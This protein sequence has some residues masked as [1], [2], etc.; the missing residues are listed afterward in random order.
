MQESQTLARNF[1]LVGVI[2]QAKVKAMQN[3]EPQR[4]KHSDLLFNQL[5]S[6]NALPHFDQTC[7]FLILD[8][9]PQPNLKSQFSPNNTSSEL[10]PDGLISQKYV[11]KI[12][13]T[14]FTI[15]S[16]HNLWQPTE[17]SRIFLIL[18]R[19]DPLGAQQLTS[20]EKD[21]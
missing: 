12:T 14:P 15:V 16:V 9:I 10:Y 8:Q 1:P 17:I 2:G 21:Q 19:K 18:A 13:S 6:L 11:E 7:R 20:M 5:S 3:H 4:Y